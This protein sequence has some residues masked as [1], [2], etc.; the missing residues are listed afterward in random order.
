MIVPVLTTLLFGGYRLHCEA[1]CL[2]FLIFLGLLSPVLGAFGRRFNRCG[3]EPP[4]RSVRCHSDVQG[5]AA[6][7]WNAK[8]V[9]IRSLTVAFLKRPIWV[10]KNVESVCKMFVSLKDHGDGRECD[11][12][13]DRECVVSDANDANK[14]DKR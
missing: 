2:R 12:S 9:L 4:R 13:N 7:L 6:R 5:R 11:R 3:C 8:R 1:S 10:T 14:W